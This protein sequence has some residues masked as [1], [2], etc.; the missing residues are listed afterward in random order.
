MGQRKTRDPILS[1]ARACHTPRQM[2]EELFGWS[3]NRKDT[4][5]SA[6]TAIQKRSAHC[7]EAAL[8]AAAVLEVH[9]YPPVI[10]SFESQDG[11]DHIIYVFREKRDQGKF[12][13]IA[14]SRDE[15][16]HGR[17]PIYSSLRALAQSYLDP[18]VDKTGRI[19]AYECFHLDECAADWRRSRR[20]VWP[21]E[22]YLLQA[23]HQPLK[24]TEAQYQKLLRAY[25]RR[26]PMPR[27]KFWWSPSPVA[28]AAD[29]QTGTL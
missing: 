13:A 29:A 22:T 3:Y 21:T 28:S 17:P 4:L 26:G 14:R 16:L 11:L 24:S 15:G 8:A 5:Y 1:L 9:G 2:Q 27:Q 10:I 23:P 18:Y 20:S 7:M 25:L 12:G 6:A 19:T